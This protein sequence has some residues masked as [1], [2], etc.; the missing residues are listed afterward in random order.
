MSVRTIRWTRRALARLDL[1]GEHIA[2]DNLA[3]SARIIVR[4]TSSVEAIAIHPAM[5]RV[6]RIAG[7]RELV[8]TPLPYLVAYRVTPET[9]DI[10]TVLHSAEKWPEAL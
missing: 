1:I 4:L 6:G 9:I 5:G 2:K 3:A 10:L 7:T 8:V